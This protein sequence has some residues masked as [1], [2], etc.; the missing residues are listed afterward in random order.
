[1]AWR[2]ANS[3]VTLRNQVDSLYPNRNKAS[4]GTIGDASHAAVKSEHNPNDA[5]VV[6]AID[7]TQDPGSG[8]DMQKLADQLIASGDNRIWYIIFNRRIWERGEGW[9]AYSGT[10]DPHTNHLHLSTNQSASLYDD[11]RQWN[12]TN[13]GL[14]VEQFNQLLGYIKNL[15]KQN[16]YRAAE[17]RNLLSYIKANE[18]GDAETRKKL[19]QGVP[20][21]NLDDLRIVKKG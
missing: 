13:G 20:P 2:L 16:E 14:T 8:A 15:E 10:S 6:T 17:I 21:V 7:I 12:L 9:S 1:M 11:G 4:D 5:G 18:L 3:L 19:E